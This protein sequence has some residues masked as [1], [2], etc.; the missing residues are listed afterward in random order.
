MTQQELDPMTVMVEL[1]ET[2]IKVTG[3]RRI[4]EEQRAELLRDIKSNLKPYDESTR[5]TCMDERRREH[6]RSG[7][8]ITEVR[9][10][11]PGGP[12]VYGLAIAELTGSFAGS[13]MTAEQRLHTIM[14]ANGRAGLKSGGHENCAANNGL[15]TWV[16]L[17][18][19]QPEKISAY[20]QSKIAEDG[21]TY[22]QEKMNAII[23]YAQG[24]KDS[25]VY[26]AWSEEKYAVL[27]GD[28]AGVAI[29]KLYDEPHLGF[30]VMWVEKPGYTIDQT[31]LNNRAFEL[32]KPYMKRIE[33]VE[34]SGPD[35]GKIAELT[36][37]A[38]YASIAALALAVPNQVLYEGTVR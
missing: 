12:D 25:G 17:I 32:N 34:A 13:T 20:V 2:P 5:G 15:G 19:E 18:A 22:D 30:A 24:V 7:G 11:A 33:D 1:H 8:K 21:L 3:E 37:Y 10:S 28:E 31:A 6:L 29:E 35:A 26:A 36:P 16:P 23:G 4:T 9:P 27:L 14:A 38:R